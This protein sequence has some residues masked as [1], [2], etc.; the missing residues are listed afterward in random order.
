M[1]GRLDRADEPV[2]VGILAAKPGR[3]AHHAVA[4]RRVL[5]QTPYRFLTSENM[6]DR[7]T[8]VI[9]HLC[10]STGTQDGRC[11]V[12]QS[13]HTDGGREEVQIVALLI[14]HGPGG[15][16]FQRDR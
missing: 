11:A 4:L 9:E 5:L 7:Q 8:R 13:E 16:L 2:K 6:L 10:Q 12:E 15:V 3:R 14:G 1:F